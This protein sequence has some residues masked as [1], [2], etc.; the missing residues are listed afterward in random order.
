M[1]GKALHYLS[2]HWPK[3]IRCVEDGDYPLDNNAG[4]NAL[5]PFV[6]GRKNWLFSDTVRGAHAS[7]NLYSLIDT[8]K[9]HGLEPYRYLRRVFDDLPKATTVEDIEA[10]L[11]WNINLAEPLPA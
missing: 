8:A 9:A 3:L 5:R 11:P 10:L 4:E 6:V 7:A 1:L 2:A